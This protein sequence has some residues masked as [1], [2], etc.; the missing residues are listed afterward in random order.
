MRSEG[1]DMSGASRRRRPPLGVR[2]VYGLMRE[3]DLDALSD[4][5]LIAVRDAQNRA[6][7]SGP[8]R[9]LTGRPDPGA[10]IAWRRL[11]L[12]DRVLPVRVYRPARGPAGPGAGLP[13]V[14]HVHGGGFAGTAAQCDWVS[15]R[16]AA[17]L[18]AVVVSVEHRLVTPGTPGVP[19]AAAVEDGWDALRHVVEHAAQ[20]DVDAG[21]VA[22]MGES[23]GG[24]V[25]ALAAVRAARSGL[26]LRAQVLVNPCTDLTPTALD[27][28]SVAEYA[29]SPTLTRAR[30]ELFRRLAV[31]EGADA[32]AVSPMYAED[33][34]GLAPA[35][36]V[37]P[38]LD[39]LADHGRAYAARLREAG[40]PA[41]VAEY[42]RAGHAFI[43]MPTLVPAARPARR[44][45][46]AF[47]RGHLRPATAS[48][49]AEAADR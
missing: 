27:H 14:V 33:L 11:E 42:R 5:E 18:P 3:P 22:V 19:F 38:S 31:P 29:D 41:R 47:L 34:G 10:A 26:P 46:L 44:E 20:W 17:R 23:A 24:A 35:L 9:V 1:L 15:S 36:V 7:V 43:S 13:L 28:P 6:V 21:R 45:I 25:A 12:P 2:L 32:R 30:L 39:P 49:A 48:S 16:I 8:V 37:V 4:D 40:T